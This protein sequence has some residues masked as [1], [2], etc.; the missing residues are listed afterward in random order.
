MIASVD[1][2]ELPATAPKFK[3][4]REGGGIGPAEDMW[5][6]E[7]VEAFINWT[8]AR[9]GK[10]NL[11]TN[12]ALEL[13]GVK[14]NID[15]YDPDKKIGYEYV[16]KLDPE[17]DYFTKDVRAKFDTWRKANTAAILFIEV[18]KNPD[19]ATL[20]GKIVKFLNA[21]KKSPPK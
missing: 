18:K 4:F 20:R 15:A 14:F 3:I 10:L 17:A 7:E 13:D 12:Y 1:G 8:M 21:V 16:D 2:K 11:K 9:E 6:P 19:A 5:Q